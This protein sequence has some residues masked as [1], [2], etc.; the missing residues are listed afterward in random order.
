VSAGSRYA[1][2]PLWVGSGTVPFVVVYTL[3]GS[4]YGGSGSERLGGYI[5][6]LADLPPSFVNSAVTVSYGP[7]GELKA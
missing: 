6:S 5:P 4:L 1:A 3:Y 7:I 2:G